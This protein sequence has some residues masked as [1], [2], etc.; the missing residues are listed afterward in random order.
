M[1]LSPGTRLGPYEIL[2]RLGSGGM[3]DVYRARDT[4]L[5]RDV[6]VKVLPQQAEPERLVR[7]EREAQALSAVSHPH[8]LAIFDVGTHDGAP[9]LV[10]ELL[11]GSTLR[12]RIAGSALPQR[13]ALE[14]ARQ[15]AR[16]LAAAHER[17]IVHRDLKPE[18]VVVSRDGHAKV[19]D[20]GLARL[21]R[22]ERA[23]PA[24]EL[25]TAGRVLGTV[26]YMSP[27][28]VRGERA[29]ARSDI[30]SFGA[31]LHEMVT[32]RRAFER[33][34]P[35]ETMNAI[36][37]D[38]PPL[39]RETN[40]GTP[41]A[42]VRLI[43]HCLEKSPDERFQS[44]RDLAFGL[45]TV[46]ELTSGSA[47]LSTGVPARRRRTLRVGAALGGVL[48]LGLGLGGLLAPHDVPDA[49]LLTR[50]TFRR[51][52]IESARFTSDG[53]TVVYGAYWDGAP[54]EVFSARPGSPESRPLGFVGAEILAISPTGEMALSLQ[55]RRVGTFVATGMLA[56]APL[57]GGVPREVH[58]DVQEADWAPDGSALSLVLSGA[59]RNRLEYPA[60]KVLYETA[61]W[62]SHHRIS[63]AGDR[64]AFLDHPVSGDDGGN[65]AVVDRSGQ[66]RVLSR[67]W[68]SVHGLAWSRSGDEI[69]FTGTREGSA[70]A[71]QAV[72]LA[73]KERT[74]SRMAGTLTLHDVHRDG[75]LLLSHQVLRREIRVLPRG[76]SQERDLS[77]LDYCFPADLSDD[78]SMLFFAENGE[79]GGRGYSAYLRRTDGSPA[80]RLG[81]GAALALS[82]DARV[83]LT[84]MDYTSDAQRLVLVPTGVGEPRTLPAAE[85]R[86]YAASF[87]PDGGRLLLVGNEAARPARVYEQSVG[88][89]AAHP[90]GPEDAGFALSARPISPDGR[91]LALRHGDGRQLL[92]PVDGGAAQPARGLR[93]DDQ[94]IR[95]SGDGRSL[96]V[97]HPGLIPAEV[98]RVDVSSGARV[99]WRQLEPADRA[100]VVAVTPVLLSADGAAY[101]Y[102]Y[103]RVL[104]D[105]YVVDGLR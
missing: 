26:G 74:V 52:T 68:S 104:S 49:P 94:V 6:A 80:V 60:G 59:G 17:G 64:L 93:A 85:F 82:P 101:V 32:G 7:F 18:N 23:E 38:D 89:G 87:F 72:T 43:A 46:A 12:E 28:Q 71:L 31:I 66:Y 61:G 91:W 45:D 10:T 27:E 56:R 33:E 30:F 5:A 14:Y 86:T 79:G 19:L 102:G 65:V 50:L 1:E 77:W 11:E 21:A 53:Q 3:G 63:A 40:A 29:D 39:L 47:P 96:F 105:L 44:A 16:G 97:Y 70:R 78:G 57:A 35:V 42:V 54:G 90:L 37:H 13:K 88:G 15:I 51:G 24:D 95:W 2:A 75:R 20:F 84:G 9:Y 99:P 67:G 100:G 103:R 25:L 8:L 92:H 4:R 83:V 81:G 58:E 34:T 36:L 22:E 69:W 76:A 55:R 62:I 48:A 73:G 98:D 41:V